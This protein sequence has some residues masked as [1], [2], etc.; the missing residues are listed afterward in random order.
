MG[1]YLAAKVDEI[2]AK[3]EDDSFLEDI[4]DAE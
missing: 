4:E 1:D 2:I 3:E